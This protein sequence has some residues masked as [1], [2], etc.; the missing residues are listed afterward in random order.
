[1][2]KDVLGKLCVVVKNTTGGFSVGTTCLVKRPP[3]V[4]S[5]YYILS[6]VGNNTYWRD[7]MYHPREDFILVEDAEQCDLL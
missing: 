3:D 5:K 6:I 4:H 7:E 2:E 1:M